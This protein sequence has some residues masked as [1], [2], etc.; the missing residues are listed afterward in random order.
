MNYLNIVLSYED[1]SEA[2]LKYYWVQECKY[3][4]KQDFKQNSQPVVITIIQKY[5]TKDYI[6][7]SYDKYFKD[8][9]SI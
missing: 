1:I 5:C 3:K 6:S 8:R 9:Q 7:D 2:F 4:I